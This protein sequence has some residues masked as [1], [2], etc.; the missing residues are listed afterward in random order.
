MDGTEVRKLLRSRK[1]LQAKTEIQVKSKCPLC[2][3]GFPSKNVR[4]VRV[5]D[6]HVKQTQ[7]TEYS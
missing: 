5:C 1:V 3:L 7:Y 4:I 2:N 6:I